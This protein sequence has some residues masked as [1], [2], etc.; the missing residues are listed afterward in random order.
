MSLLSVSGTVLSGAATFLLTNILTRLLV[1][2]AA[3][4][5]QQQ[6]WKWR[7]VATSLVHSLIT[8]LWALKAFY[9]VKLGVDHLY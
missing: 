6:R 3:S 9:E 4:D 8:G 2:P 7:N 1:P 5:N